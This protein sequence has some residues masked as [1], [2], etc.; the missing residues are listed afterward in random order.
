MPNQG[1]GNQRAVSGDFQARCVKPVNTEWQ[2]KAG[3]RAA[4][5]PEMERAEGLL[6]TLHLA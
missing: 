6:T 1:H 5:M 4:T 3:T 2:W